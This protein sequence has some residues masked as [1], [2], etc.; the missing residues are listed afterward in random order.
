[1]KKNIILTLL[2]LL[3]ISGY[4][5]TDPPVVPVEFESFNLEVKGYGVELEWY[6]ASELN[7][8][9]FVIE[10]GIVTDTGLDWEY[11]TSIEGNGTTKSRHTYNYQDHSKLS[12]LIYY[13]LSQVDYDNTMQYLGTVMTNF[14]S[15]YYD[16]I[17]LDG[18]ILSIKKMQD[19]STM[20]MVVI[21]TTRKTYKI[22]KL[23]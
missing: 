11:I 8:S 17:K 4:A 21:R 1:M 12:G 13:K 15:S 9:H 22:V 23:Y 16:N 19:N 18:N 6:T 5:Q 20:N 7:N 2:I 14:E 3:S 10:R